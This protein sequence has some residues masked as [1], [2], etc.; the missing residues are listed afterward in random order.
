MFVLED[1][2]RFLP[3]IDH[4]NRARSG[5]SLVTLVIFISIVILWAIAMV[6]NDGTYA[7]QK[8]TYHLGEI[9]MVRREHWGWLVRC[10][11]AYLYILACGWQHTGNRNEQSHLSN[12]HGGF[13]QIAPRQRFES[14]RAL[15][16]LLQQWQRSK[17]VIKRMY[18]KICS[19]LDRGR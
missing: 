13:V 3:V 19:A 16:M 2:I 9:I 18:R 7:E 15:Y 4:G 14:E 5:W 17:A 10:G 12:V 11:K 1:C 6:S 8:G